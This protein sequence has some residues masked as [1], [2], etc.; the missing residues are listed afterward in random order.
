[1]GLNIQ[2]MMILIFT[3]LM[4]DYIFQTSQMAYNKTKS[5][6]GVLTHELIVLLTS[7]IILSIY[8]LNGFLMAGIISISHFV[9]DYAKMKANRLFKIEIVG[10]LIDQLLHLGVIVLCVYCFGSVANN[11]IL[12]I[13]YIGVINYLLIITFIA[14]VVVKVIMADIFRSSIHQPDFFMKNERVFDCLIVVVAA[15]SFINVLVG[16]VISAAAAGAFF[17]AEI[18]YFRYSKCQTLIKAALY[19]IFACL[20]RFL[21]HY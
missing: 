12:K 19:F 18:R 8:G 15:F 11:P 10:Y 3:H 14:T 21:M 20:F 6:K 17:F 1:M 16:I 4:A 9:I 13:K 5:L 2:L 7:T